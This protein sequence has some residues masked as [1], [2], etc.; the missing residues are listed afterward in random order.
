MPSLE[1]AQAGQRGERLVC[2]RRSPSRDHCYLNLPPLCVCRMV[3]RLGRR[4]SGRGPWTRTRHRPLSV[5]PGPDLLLQYSCMRL[6]VVYVTLTF[7]T[8]TRSNTCTVQLSCVDTAQ[9]PLCRVA[10]FR[11]QPQHDDRRPHLLTS[12]DSI[13][14]S[15]RTSQYHAIRLYDDLEGRT[16]PTI[17]SCVLCSPARPHRPFSQSRM[18]M[19]HMRCAPRSG[20][21]LRGLSLARHRSSQSRDH[22]LRKCRDGMV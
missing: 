16:K 17:R 5:S 15:R 4:A 6:S 21:R 9:T 2:S 1:P 22:C 13:L 20:A 19:R 3:C 8:V 11:R 12:Q 7:T 10:R 14:I 18:L